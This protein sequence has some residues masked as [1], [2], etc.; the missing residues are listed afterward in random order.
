[1]WGKDAEHNTSTRTFAEGPEYEWVEGWGKWPP[2]W[3]DFTRT[4][5]YFLVFWWFLGQ[6]VVN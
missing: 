4:L 5:L 3:G 2:G 6:G 1:M